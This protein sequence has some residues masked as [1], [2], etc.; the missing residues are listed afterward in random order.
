MADAKPIK[1]GTRVEVIGKGVV[2]TVGYIGTT[3]FS[4]GTVL[5]NVHLFVILLISYVF[6]ILIY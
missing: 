1:M 2:G 6:D 3:M 5:L 4:S